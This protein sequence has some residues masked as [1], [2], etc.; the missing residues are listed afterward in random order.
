MNKIYILIFLIC[1]FIVSSCGEK[2]FPMPEN[3][4]MKE[5]YDLGNNSQNLSLYLK[6]FDKET[7]D[8]LVDAYIDKYKDK[9]LAMMKFKIYD[10]ELPADLID[11][12][13]APMKTDSLGNAV[14]TFPPKG[15]KSAECWYW[16]KTSDKD[17]G[18]IKIQK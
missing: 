11:K 13:N 12:I 4:I 8:K 17:M 3:K 16:F 10:A 1:V 5:E 14:I 6:T 15:T 2:T 7:I 9:K 18:D